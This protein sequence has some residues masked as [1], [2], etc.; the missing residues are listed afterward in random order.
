MYCPNCA[1]QIDG[2]KFCRTCGANVS[3]VPQ[4]LTGKLAEEKAVGYDVE[5]KPDDR[6]GRRRRH[7]DRPVSLSSGIQNI[8]RGVG[9]LFVAMAVNIW[10]PA[11]NLWWFWMLIPA[12]SLLG[13]GIAE[14]VRVR[15]EA[16][17]AP[18]PVQFPAAQIPTIQAAPQTNELPPQPY[19]G[20]KAP[21]SVIEGT[22][23][24]LDPRRH[25]EPNA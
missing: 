13:K 22:T 5:G 21:P 15:H 11:G 8:I 2:T 3:L 12:F 20:I 18:P 16:Q 19:A 6:H 9:F 10:A 1:A 23:R 24:N 17:P 7:R 25:S 14:I 4:A